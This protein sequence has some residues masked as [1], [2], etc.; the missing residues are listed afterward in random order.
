MGV[1]VARSDT[2]WEISVTPMELTA[3]GKDLFKQD[4]LVRSPI[5]HSSAADTDQLFAEPAPNA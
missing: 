1:K 5:F 3:K 4:S 2:G